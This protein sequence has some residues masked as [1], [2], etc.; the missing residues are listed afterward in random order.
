[1][2]KVYDT[3]YPVIDI[4]AETGPI[5]GVNYIWHPEFDL[6][7]LL[8]SATGLLA[9]RKL[10]EA[11]VLRPYGRRNGLEGL[12]LQRFVENAWFSTY[13][14]AQ[15]I[16]GIMVLWNSEW[17]WDYTQIYLNAKAHLLDF[18][19]QEIA[20]LRTYYLVACGFYTQALFGLLFI[21]ERMKD[22]YEMVTHHIITIALIGFS[23]VSTFHRWGSIII[24]LH[25]VVDIFL[26][27]AKMAHEVNKQTVANVL[28]FTFTVSFFILRLVVLPFLVLNVFFNLI[29]SHEVLS[30]YPQAYW[31]FK[32]ITNFGYPFDV[33]S[34]GLCAFHYC[35]STPYFLLAFLGLL[36]CLHVYWFSIVVKLLIKTLSNSGN[37]PH[38][39]RHLEIKDGK[40]ESKN[41][42][43]KSKLEANEQEEAAN[44]RA[45][46]ADEMDRVAQSQNGKS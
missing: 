15:C 35:V 12:K 1:M 22:F 43:S 20:G 31:V 3:A 27:S 41:S 40:K 23:I 10:L 25:D 19:R 24:L 46:Q 42:G 33:N 11:F 36:I 14:V 5:H 32:K 26:Y 4:F 39:P 7:V 9:L 6:T 34:H 21:D 13:Y 37:V 29:Y 38:D 17:L 45:P 30:Q 18:E 44:I 8:L 2:T 16:F 28:F